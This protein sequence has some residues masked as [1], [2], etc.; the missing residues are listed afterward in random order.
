MHKVSLFKI[1]VS[2]VS[3]VAIVCYLKKKKVGQTKSLDITA[4]IHYLILEDLV[5]LLVGLRSVSTTCVET[6][7]STSPKM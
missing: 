3:W 5:F 1:I 7:D 4:F 6:S 2:V